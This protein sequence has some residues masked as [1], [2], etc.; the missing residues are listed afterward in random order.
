MYCADLNLALSVDLGCAE[1]EMVE[2]GAE[3]W[4]T[5]GAARMGEGA[6]ARAM[7]MVEVVE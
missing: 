6:R 5:L 2:A 7:V 1:Q 3:M 4:F